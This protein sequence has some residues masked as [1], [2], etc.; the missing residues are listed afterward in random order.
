MKSKILLFALFISVFAGAQCP[1]GDIIFNSQI[2]VDSFVELY[3]N[4]TEISGNLT[5]DSQSE[6][7]PIVNL[8]GLS[9]LNSVTGQ[10]EILRLDYFDSEIDS[11]IP[12]SL[13]GLEGI[14]QVDRLKIGEDS[15]F[16]TFHISDLSPLG[17]L[18]GSVSSIEL[19]SVHFYSPLPNFSNI[20][21]LLD[22]EM[23]K[24][25][26]V[27]QTPSFP[28]LQNLR[29][30]SVIGA[31]NQIDSL[32]IVNVP[33][34]ND[35]EGDDEA[36]YGVKV[37]GCPQVSV[38]QGGVGLESM[39]NVIVEDNQKLN[40]ISAFD[41]LSHVNNRF[42]LIA[43]QP[44]AFDSFKNLSFSRELELGINTFCS[45]SW[46]GNEAIVRVGE[47]ASELRV[48]GQYFTIR[49][50]AVEEITLTAT[51]DKVTGLDLRFEGLESFNG[52]DELDSLVQGPEFQGNLQIHTA[53]LQSFPSFP[54]LKYIHRR[55]TIY[56]DD[57]DCGVVDM[58]GFESLTY[59]GRELFIQDLVDNGNFQSLNGLSSIT[60]LRD[61]I[62]DELNGFTD[63]SQ[64]SDVDFISDIKLYDLPNIS[65]EVSFNNLNSL[66]VLELHNLGIAE[67][68]EFPVLT[69]I[70][71]MRIGNCPNFT[72]ITN[73]PE[74]D[75]VSW[76][77]LTNNPLFEE[78]DLSMEIV[79]ENVEWIN[80]PS[81][82]SCPETPI[83]CH[84]LSQ[85][86]PTF[87]ELN[88]NGSSCN[89]IEEILE[90]CLLSLDDQLQNDINMWSDHSG[91]LFIESSL[92]DQVQLRAYDLHGNVVFSK[93]VLLNTSQTRVEFPSLSSSLY[94]V[95]LSN[96]N[97]RINKKVFIQ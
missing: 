14:T 88:N 31:T 94:L 64:L 10:L 6:E 54:S 1:V 44:G 24:C 96:E 83:I 52:F 73:M 18:A 12:G 66:A 13:E 80:N 50:S 16:M 59:V 82:T 92:S 9:E 67:P 53:D 30:Y 26:G 36:F 19:S 85:V 74:L 49:S 47:N 75:Y 63:L 81:L 95:E 46:E 72:T 86:D 17:N 57:I 37:S 97:Y 38:I 4:C 11:L 22:F 21:F 23:K 91:N 41:D 65:S 29:S 70:G 56:I 27:E 79:V 2:D 5:I 55:F 48:I 33:N 25:N 45:E 71:V 28:N 76:I 42:S 58:T 60:Y 89:D 78:I 15:N 90:Q 68:F 93:I 69:S 51:V 77:E 61:L 40:S 43:C 32:Q 84:I 34:V 3:P 39:N 35:M 20:L 7:N 62:M 8:T 87:S